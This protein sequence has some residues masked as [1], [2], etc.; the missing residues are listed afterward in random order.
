MTWSQFSNDVKNFVILR[1]KQR[2]ISKFLTWIQPETQIGFH[3]S[4]QRH[5]QIKRKSSGHWK[6]EVFHCFFTPRS[7]LFQSKY[8]PI[9]TICQ[10]VID[11][12]WESWI[13]YY[14][15]GLISFLLDFSKYVFVV[16]DDWNCPPDIEWWR[17]VN[18]S[19]VRN[20]TFEIS[21]S[22]EENTTFLSSLESNPS[23][24]SIFSKNVWCYPSRPF[25][26]IDCSLDNPIVS[27][28]SMP[29]IYGPDQND[30][31]DNAYPIH[32]KESLCK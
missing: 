11:S 16:F 28:F 18:Q 14:F 23:L 4:K 9:K 1:I 20:M 19:K 3:H 17:Y 22:N 29:K 24:S 12:E 5:I 7:L 31:I 30:Q 13:T 25:E 32:R 6:E 26:S 27:W 2:L 21:K 8:H 10:V 15:I